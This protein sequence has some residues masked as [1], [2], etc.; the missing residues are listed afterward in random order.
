MEARLLSSCRGGVDSGDFE[1]IGGVD[2]LMVRDSKAPLKEI[3]FPLF[4]YQKGRKGRDMEGKT[5]SPF[6]Q[7]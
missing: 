5:S 3:A 7:N 2:V 1:G 4:G 6:K